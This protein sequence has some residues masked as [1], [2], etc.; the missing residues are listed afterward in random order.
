MCY[1]LVAFSLETCFFQAYINGAETTFHQSWWIERRT[2]GYGKGDRGFDQT[3][4]LYLCT[5]PK[6]EHCKIEL[7]ERLTSEKSDMN[8]SRVQ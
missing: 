2:S 5:W 8:Q 3:A 4:E 6:S 7:N 1:V